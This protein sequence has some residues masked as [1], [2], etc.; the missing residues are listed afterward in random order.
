MLRAAG[1]AGTQVMWDLM[2]Y[3]W[4]DDLTSGRR[5]S[6]T[7]F[8]RFA[9]AAARVVR[10]ETDAMPFYCPINEISFHA[11]GGGEAAYLNPYTR[12][13]GFELKVQLARASI[14]AMHEILAVDPRARFVHCEPAINIVCDPARFDQRSD[15]N[16]RNEAQYQAW[17]LL[18]GRL[19]PQLGGSLRFLDILGVNYYHNN[20]W[21]H[22]QPPID[23][24]HPLYKPFRNILAEN[25]A[26]YNRPLFVA[27]TGIEGDRRPSW[28]AYIAAETDQAR[29]R[30]VPVEGI[31]LYPT[32]EHPGWDDDRPCEN[33][34]LSSQINGGLR[35]VYEPLAVELDR[36]QTAPEN[37]RASRSSVVV[38]KRLN[39]LTA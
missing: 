18:G 5:P 32:V 39:E 34:L 29:L 14:A 11:W 24:G 31:C 38:N 36:W 26:R 16:G 23:I 20:Q 7:R 6:S 37:V 13:R 9:A 25:F 15:V 1:R 10:D 27:E 8:A 22:G 19:W 4:P 35:R 21:I 2:H 17:D 30:G 33:G 28:L 3:G 12:G